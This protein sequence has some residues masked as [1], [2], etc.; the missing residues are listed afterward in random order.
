MTDKHNLETLKQAILRAAQIDGAAG[1]DSLL[2]GLPR[3]DPKTVALRRLAGQL[4]QDKDGSF[5][6]DERRP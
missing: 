2:A 4:V 5:S 6:F 3:L 1:V